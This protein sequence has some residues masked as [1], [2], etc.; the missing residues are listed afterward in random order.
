MRPCRPAQ[1]PF[2][3]NAA[4]P[5]LNLYHHGFARVAV[6]EPG[7]RFA[8]PL[9]NAGETAAMRADASRQ[10][11]RLV[12]LPELGLAAYTCDDLF[13]QRALLDACKAA[14]VRCIAA[15]EGCAAVAVV[16]LPVRADRSL[17]NCAAVMHAGRL[18]GIVPKNWYINTQVSKHNSDQCFN[19]HPGECTSIRWFA[20]RRFVHL[21]KRL[22]RTATVL[23]LRC[24]DP[25]TAG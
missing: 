21:S 2:R 14:L 25:G 1:G 7:C 13:H 17:F 24:V 4:T 20:A 8:G 6:A 12:V 16:R 9:F 19:Q 10:G 5:Y 15:S 18:L 11:A 3:L 23:C 22:P